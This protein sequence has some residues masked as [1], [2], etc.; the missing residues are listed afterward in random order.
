M[1]KD[2]DSGSRP[3]LDPGI[4]VSEVL[5]NLEFIFI[6]QGIVLPIFVIIGVILNFMC[7]GV[8]FHKCFRSSPPYCLLK[9]LTLGDLAILFLSVYSDIQ[10]AITAHLK[11]QSLVLPDEKLLRDLNS[12]L[13][14]REKKDLRQTLR[15]SAE[16]AEKKH[17]INVAYVLIFVTCCLLPPVIGGNVLAHLSMTSFKQHVS[18]FVKTWVIVRVLYVSNSGLNCL[19]YCLI[20]RRFRRVFLDMYFHRCRRSNSDGRTGFSFAVSPEVSSKSRTTVHISPSI[21][22]SGSLMIRSLPK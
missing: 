7:L 17:N 12:L 11:V 3:D 9:A 10:P 16:F 21:S 8:L 2:T 22:L 13:M 4:E 15:S 20:A 14:K 19:C 1:E 18:I 5:N 6:C